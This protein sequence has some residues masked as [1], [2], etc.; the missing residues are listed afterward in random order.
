MLVYPTNVQ[1]DYLKTLYKT[2]YSTARNNG[3]KIY[4]TTR[5]CKQYTYHLRKLLLTIIYFDSKGKQCSR[6]IIFKCHHHRQH[7]RIECAYILRPLPTSNTPSFPALCIAI[8][9]LSIHH[10]L[11][12]CSSS[13]PSSSSPSRRSAEYIPRRSFLSKRQKQCKRSSVWN[14]HGIPTNV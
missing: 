2:A 4:Q 6:R 13:S 10:C 14:L 3:Q 7:H 5:L 9:R 11:L 1:Y 12:P 8:H